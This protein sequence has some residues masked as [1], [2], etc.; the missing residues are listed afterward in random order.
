MAGW[1]SGWHALGAWVTMFL[2][3]DIIG[4][5]FIML[6]WECAPYIKKLSLVKDRD[7]K[8]R[9]AAV[10]FLLYGVIWQIWDM[11]I[12]PTKKLSPIMDELFSHSD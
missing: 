6:D 11:L 5:A 1:E 9:Y 4:A 2:I 8:F 3:M 12:G 7:K 10:S